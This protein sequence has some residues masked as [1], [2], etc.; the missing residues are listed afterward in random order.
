MSTVLSP[1][2]KSSR[3]APHTCF[4]YANPITT[5]VDHLTIR[6]P[7]PTNHATTLITYLYHALDVITWKQ[8]LLDNAV[9]GLY[10]LI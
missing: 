7:C 2:V 10:A 3:N 1:P 5:Y 4:V 8:T 9:S 6:A